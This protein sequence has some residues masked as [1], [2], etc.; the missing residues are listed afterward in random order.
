MA[1]VVDFELL[2]AERAVQRLSI[3][4][5]HRIDARQWNGL[6]EA[7]FTPDASIEYRKTLPDGSNQ[8]IQPARR[9]VTTPSRS[10][11]RLRMC[12]RSRGSQAEA[13]SDNALTHWM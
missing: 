12:R 3:G 6:A 10:V 8:V 2:Q 9:G 5:F 7:F 13:S 4:Y 1:Q 11:P